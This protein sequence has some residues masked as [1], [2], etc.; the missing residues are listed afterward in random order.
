MNSTRADSGPFEDFGNSRPW[1]RAWRK[2]LREMA[3]LI[4]MSRAVAAG[5]YELATPQVAMIVGTLAYVVSP[6]DAVPDIIPVAGLVDDGAVVAGTLAALAVEIAA[7]R[8]WESEQRSA[9]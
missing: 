4:R 3:V 8:M 6:V 1:S 7:F 2:I 5:E 9:A